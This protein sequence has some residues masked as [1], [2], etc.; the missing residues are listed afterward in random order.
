MGRQRSLSE[1][2]RSRRHGEFARAITASAEAGWLHSASVVGAAAREV[3]RGVRLIGPMF[4]TEEVPVALVGAC[5]RSPAM[6]AS[7][8]RWLAKATEKR[9]TLFESNIPPIQGAVL[10][11]LREEGVA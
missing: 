1:V 5:V 4:E 3:A 9:Y 11:A 7:L 10:M 2:E 6:R 8:G